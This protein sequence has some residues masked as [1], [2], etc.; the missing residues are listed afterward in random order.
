M[1]NNVK[2][3]CLKVSRSNNRYFFEKPYKYDYTQ[4]KPGLLYGYSGESISIM[5]Y[6]KR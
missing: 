1:K 4:I 3:I 2:H 5:G 6:P